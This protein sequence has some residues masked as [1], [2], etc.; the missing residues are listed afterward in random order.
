MVK[1]EET[2]VKVNNAPQLKKAKSMEIILKEEN[3]KDTAQ[4]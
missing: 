2:K 3:Q 4:W 1:I